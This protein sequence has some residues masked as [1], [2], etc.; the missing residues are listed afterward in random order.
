[1]LY[2]LFTEARPDYMERIIAIVGSKFDGFT[3]LPGLGYYQ[4]K[5]EPCVIVE[6]AVPDTDRSNHGL[7]V[8]ALAEEIC[9]V[10]NQECV[11]VQKIDTA[12]V[13]IHAPA[14]VMAAP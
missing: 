4:G 11:L 2:R 13:M 8:Q 9:R 1:M 6:I 14:P 7:V 12:S 3:L 5:P 10:N